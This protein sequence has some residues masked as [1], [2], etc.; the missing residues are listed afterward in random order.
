MLMDL[1]KSRLTEASRASDIAVWMI[2]LMNGIKCGKVYNWEQCLAER[3]H[4]FL[5]LEHKTFY[6]CHHAISLF[7]DV[8]RL[9]VP[10][11]MWGTFELHGRVE[12][13]K[14]TIYYYT[15]L[16]TLGDTVQPTKKRRKLDASIEV[17]DVSN[18]EDSEEVEEI[19]VQES[20]DE[21]SHLAGHTVVE[22]E[23]ETESQQQEEEEEEEQHGGLWA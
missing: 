19:E 1:V 10:P 16:D 6:M 12:P 9:Q 5:R 14:P 13:N 20:G 11:E 21:G 4:D 22:E 17:K 3:I 15:H 8:V 23:G 2:G 18:V 7:L